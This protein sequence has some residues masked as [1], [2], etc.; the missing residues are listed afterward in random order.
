[1]GYRRLG[2]LIFCRFVVILFLLSYNF[3]KLK[4]NFVACTFLVFK[5]IV[6]IFLDMWSH[7]TLV[8]IILDRRLIDAACPASPAVAAAAWSAARSLDPRSFA[9]DGSATRQR[10]LTT[11]L[12]LDAIRLVQFKNLHFSFGFSTLKALNWWGLKKYIYEDIWTI[13]PAPVTPQGRL[14]KN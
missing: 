14:Q 6:R 11:F 2:I 5:G 9:A 7:N 8:Y 3:R 1:M 12:Q 10:R 4:L 13:F